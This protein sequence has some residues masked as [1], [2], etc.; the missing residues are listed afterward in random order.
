MEYAQQ[1]LQYLH[2]LLTGL[3]YPGDSTQRIYWL[4]LIGALVIASLVY[5]AANRWVFNLR[6]FLA[7][8][9]PKSIYL[10]RSAITDYGYFIL[11][12]ALWLL[13]LG[14]L[15][16]TSTA[17][18]SA[19]TDSLHHLLGRG[20]W[21]IS[22]GWPTQVALALALMIASDLAIFLTHYM[23]HKV[24]LLWEFHKVHH[25]AEV[26]TPITVY[27]MHP[28]D[29]LFTASVVGITTGIV[30]GLFDFSFQQ[31]VT[32]MGVLSLNVFVFV[33]Y[34]LGYNLRHSHIWLSY[35]RLH[36]WLISPAQHQI[37]HS[38]EEKHYDKNFGF[39]LACWDRWAGSLYVPEKKEALVFGLGK[40]QD[41]D[42]QSVMRLFLLPFPRALKRLRNSISSWVVM[43]FAI[44][45]IGSFTAINAAP[46]P[47]PSVWLEELT[48][49]EV[50]QLIDAGY[51]R[52]IIPTG[53][54][55]QNGPHMILGKHNH[56]VH[57]TAE[58][59]ARRLGNTLVAPVI[60][61][62]PEGNIDP[63]EG[64]MRFAGTLSISDEVFEQLLEQT[65]TSLRAHG[66]RH[67]YLIGDSFGNQKPQ[68]CVAEKLSQQW[69]DTKVHHIGD[70]YAANGQFDWLRS[71]GETTESIG[72]HAGIR[73]TSELMAV[74]PAG[75][76]MQ[77][78]AVNGGGDTRETG[79]SGDP[80]KATTDLGIKMLNMKIEAAVMQFD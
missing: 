33:F 19:L 35:G 68:E 51:D 41:Q 1:G 20:E 37:H 49:T 25:S 42:Y 48:W 62:V 44:L 8:C 38:V 69:T 12:R 21:F 80:Q 71:Q 5:G 3:S 22:I 45:G 78:R 53:G 11:N 72:G 15:V 16:L 65:A 34:L 73:D 24:P 17:M 74:H 39:M 4:Y 2:S 79:V 31:N 54:T 14:P 18:A 27:R 47:P 7:W 75:I 60:A 40:G 9:F 56:V 50:D 23:Q 36:R 63:P 13:W 55:E 77:E 64:H 76:R 30:I 46:E 28:I 67:I 58:Q 6:G 10:H 26:L 66:F 52:I 43:L 57:Y 70:Y 29:D 32:A 59:I 61:Y